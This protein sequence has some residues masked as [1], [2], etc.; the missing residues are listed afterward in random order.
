[1]L[2]FKKYLTEAPE[3]KLPDTR[4]TDLREA[5]DLLNTKCSIGRKTLMTGDLLYRGAKMGEGVK[6]IDPSTGFRTSKDTNN[7]YQVMMDSAKDLQDVPSRSKSIICTSSG[8]NASS[9]AHDGNLWVL[10][11]YDGTELAVLNS[12]DLLYCTVAPVSATLPSLNKM[13]INTVSYYVGNWL[14][15]N[16]IISDEKLLDSSGLDEKLSKCNPETLARTFFTEFS[17]YIMG[18]NRG[19]FTYHLQGVF[20]KHRKNIFTHLSNT[21]FSKKSLNLS[22][23]EY[24]QPIAQKENEIWFSNQCLAIHTPE[25]TKLLAHLKKSGFPVHRGTQ[26][27][28]L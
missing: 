9:Y 19:G 5:I 20:E 2:T 24:G 11:P 3:I 4:D 13:Q 10:F 25:F 16:K 8:S 28:W 22:M 21:F 27:R 7:V 23:V 15:E 1:M 18:S 26:N 17:P 14:R 12:S 6:V